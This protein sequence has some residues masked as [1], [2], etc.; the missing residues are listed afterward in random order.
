[1]PMLSRSS[2]RRRPGGGS[3]T[4]IAVVAVLGLV[5][6]AW[7]L[8]ATRKPTQYTLQKWDAGTGLPHESIQALAQTPDG[9]LWL[10]TMGGLVRFDGVRFTHYTPRNSALPH[11]N[12][13][14]LAVDPS[15]RLWLGTDGGGVA[16]WNGDG[17]VQHFGK[18]DGLTSD[19]IRPILMAKDGSVWVATHGGGVNRYHD[20]HW[21][22]VT[23]KEGLA[24]D[25]VWSLAEDATGR[26]WM[27]TNGDGL[28]TWE[29]GRIVAHYGVK[30]GLPQGAIAALTF[31]RSG[32]LWVGTFDG[33]ARL[34]DGKW[35]R[36][37]RQEGLPAQV[38]RTIREDSQG[39][40]W[41]GT[42]EGVAR[43]QDDTIETLP[44]EEG[45]GAYVR[46]MIE[47]R[48]GNLWV[49]LF[50]AGLR[51]LTDETFF[52]I[53]RPE[54]APFL[55]TYTVLEAKDGAMWVGTYRGAWR[56]QGA[57]FS[58]VT[59][60]DGLPSDSIGPLA[61][62]H[63][64][65]IWIGTT[66]RGL[67]YWRAGKVRSFTQKDGLP[68]DGIRTIL[69]DHAGTVWAGTTQGL[70][71]FRD[72]HWRRQPAKLPNEVVRVLLEGKDGSL[73][74]GTAA[75]LARYREGEWTTV[76][77][78]ESKTP[79]S[80]LAL[81]EDAEAR[82]WVG[83]ADHGLCR[84]AGG[85]SACLRVEGELFDAAISTILEDDLGS[86]WVSSAKGVTRVAKTVLD[87]AAPGAKIPFE[88]FGR[89]DGMRTSQ[90][91]GG[92]TPGGARAHDG[93]LWFPTMTGLTAVD[94]HHIKKNTLA[95]VVKIEEMHADGSPVALGAPV[96]G[97]GVRRL[98]LQYTG[99]SLSSLDKVS[100]RVRLD[101]FDADWIDAGNR[102]VA[103]YT[104][105]PAGTYTFRV[106]A[107]NDDGAC[108]EKGA[109]T[110]FT[111]RPHLYQRRGFWVLVSMLALG[112]GVSAYRLRIGQLRAREQE[113]Q[114]RVDEATAH[115]KVLDGMLPICAG[116][117]KIRDDTGYWS[118][119]ETYISRNSRASFSHG[120]CPE[121]VQRLYPDY[122]A[123]AGSGAPPA[124]RGR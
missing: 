108:D 59:A 13:W 123:S 121:C 21:S 122:A 107:C 89:D 42:A 69:V 79:P 32:D 87:N 111:L 109:A 124:D 100:F 110:S 104:S 119:I 6:P 9:Y 1:M 93:R 49:G 35:T 97:P 72:R 39:N 81:Y 60:K 92:F 88:T 74:A 43:I 50:G 20:G 44:A 115:I 91:N 66:A 58:S 63:D 54:G 78:V 57:T 94:P 51:R 30:D 82:L 16:I 17:T 85:S 37:S 31:T 26:I 96:L 12:V 47:D 56:F 86:L 48:E 33:L 98:E 106:R 55:A 23:T 29:G 38:V 34:R 117:K 18:A 8:D 70:G 5:L 71:E 73:W 64:G 99:L 27:G 53:G 36:W 65:G 25:N 52:A 95:P 75:G 68:S 19:K 77:L 61:E 114:R 120:M 116:C 112:A 2:C 118:Q 101:P 103:Y 14:S 46:A 41:V 62:D 40:I 105:L 4:W 102:R 3:R 84:L 76:S 7:A 10:G 90:V 28:D 24:N 80:I 22:A 83:T 15:G 113:L 67:A 11:S 45:G